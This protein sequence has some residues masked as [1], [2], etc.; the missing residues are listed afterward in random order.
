MQVRGPTPELADLRRAQALEKAWAFIA[1]R[2]RNARVV[3][4]MRRHEKLR[5]LRWLRR[6]T[7][8]LLPA[9]LRSL[10]RSRGLTI[11][12]SRRTCSNG[13][14]GCLDAWVGE[15]RRRTSL[16]RRNERVLLDQEAVVAAADGI[17]RR[18]PLEGIDGACHR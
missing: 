16:R 7:P 2:L 8:H 5:L 3:R 6:R 18:L 11:A 1:F 17:D 4:S 15:C 13:L 9:G 12:C 14:G 10:Y